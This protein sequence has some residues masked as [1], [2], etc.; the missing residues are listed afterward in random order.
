MSIFIHS[1]C[2]IVGDTA[3]NHVAWSP[4]NQVLAAST[5]SID[6]QDKETNRVAF[7]NVEVVVVLFSLSLS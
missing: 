7:Y 5:Y 2:Q 1:N 3:V 4:C 6:E